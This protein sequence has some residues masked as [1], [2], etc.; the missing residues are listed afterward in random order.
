MRALPTRDEGGR[1]AAALDVLRGANQLAQ[2]TRWTDE[3]LAAL[4]H[5][6]L[7]QALYHR[8][9]VAEALLAVGFL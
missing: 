4:V 2:E 6:P 3:N 5:V 7:G 9:A 8:G 1:L